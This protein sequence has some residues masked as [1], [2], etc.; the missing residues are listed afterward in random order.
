MTYDAM[1]RMAS[2]RDTEFYY[3]TSWRVILEQT[4]TGGDSLRTDGPGE[5]YDDEG[6]PVAPYG[7]PEEAQPEHG[8]SR[9]ITSGVTNYEFVWSPVY[10]DALIARDADTRTIRPTRPPHA[11]TP[12]TTA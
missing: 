11:S 2:E 9:L 4:P 1:G 10:I 5:G 8:Q 6:Y 7:L 3:D 12:S